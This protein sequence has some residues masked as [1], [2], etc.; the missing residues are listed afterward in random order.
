[1]SPHDLPVGQEV[2]LDKGAAE[3][4]KKASPPPKSY[5]AEDDQG[6]DSL[7]TPD[8]RNLDQFQVCNREVKTS[9][10]PFL[11][12][13][14]AQIPVTPLGALLCLAL[15]CSHVLLH[16]FNPRQQRLMALHCPGTPCLAVSKALRLDIARAD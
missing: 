6:K 15:D 2:V 16:R 11:A 1:M 10:L 3:Q 12:S 7:T 9:L 5:K 4:I 8:G 14:L 13:Y